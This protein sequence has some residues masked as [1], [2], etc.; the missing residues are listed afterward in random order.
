MISFQDYSL[1]GLKKQLESS[2]EEAKSEVLGWIRGNYLKSS[3]TPS[4]NLDLI[5]EEFRFCFQILNAMYVSHGTDETRA[6]YQE[7]IP[8]ATEF[9]NSIWLSSEIYSLLIDRMEDYLHELTSNPEAARLFE[10]QK[11]AFQTQGAHLSEAK[12]KRLHELDSQLTLLTAQFAEEVLKSTSEFVHWVKSREDL[13]GVPEDL[14]AQMEIFAAKKR[15]S[16]V[17]NE[18]GRESSLWAVG[19]QGPT[20]QG[21]LA[22]AENRNL[23]EVI[24]RAFNSR[25]YS[26]TPGSK[27]GN[28]GL[29]RDVVRL[30]QE[31]AQILG[32]PH[33]ANWVLQNRMARS[34]EQVEEFSRKL[35][36]VAFPAAKKEISELKVFAKEELGLNEVKPWDVTFIAE[37]LK[38]KKFHFNQEELKAY[39]PISQ[40]TQ[41][42]FQ[43]LE[44]LFQLKFEAV[45]DQK[46]F[47]PEQKIFEVRRKGGYVGHLLLDFYPR[48]TKQAGA[49]MQSLRS[50]G[51]TRKGIK[52]PYSSISCNFTPPGPQGEEAYLTLQEVTTLFHEFGHAIHDLLSQCH[53]ASLSGTQVKW[54]FVELPSQLMENWCYREETLVLLSKHRE[55][56]QTLPADLIQK[57]KDS[58]RF[59][60]GY[61]TVRQLSLGALDMAWHTLPANQPK[62][63][64]GSQSDNQPESQFDFESIEEFESQVLAPYQLFD[65]VSGTS[66]ST[67]FGHIFSGGYSAGYYSYKWAEV[68]EADVFHEFEKVGVYDQAL[69]DRFVKH[70]LSA[71]NSKDPADLIREFLGR[72]PDPK[73]LLIRSG[74][75]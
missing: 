18:L 73:A 13:K 28:V 37:K 17:D 51:L 38:K 53:Y 56:G 55:T 30:R 21:V 27:S 15:K 54:D 60:Q 32:F 67:A 65:R 49:W 6:L 16:A 33:Y 20:V 10:E 23:R 14:V 62:S 48:D 39:F 58:S 12:R 74:L 31:K 25:A 29:I 47:H 9:E 7:V 4:E 71:G 5:G 44:K 45:K 35:F 72:E 68:L 75:L 63:Q 8:K 24:W 64:S 34:A 70:I 36:E 26:S 19:L 69:A 11:R 43:H 52:T 59:M 57:V 66:V 22:F 46:G 41:G 50:H 2:L 61:Q 1:P 3:L 40:V 42:L